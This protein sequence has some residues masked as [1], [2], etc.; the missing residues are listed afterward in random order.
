MDL[1]TRLL[2][3]S[4]LKEIVKDKML[5]L[6]EDALV[7]KQAIEKLLKLGTTSAHEFLSLGSEGLLWGEFDKLLKDS[8]WQISFQ[9]R[10][11]S[12]H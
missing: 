5:L 7:L 10:L 2:I 11:E 1:L 12:T 3:I 4:M 9:D 6:F 8:H